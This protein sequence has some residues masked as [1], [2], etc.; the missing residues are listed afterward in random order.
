MSQM[1]ILQGPKLS[2]NWTF[3]VDTSLKVDQMSI[4]RTADVNPDGKLC[5]NNLALKFGLT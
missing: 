4:K 5:Q 2:Q 3:E 1:Y